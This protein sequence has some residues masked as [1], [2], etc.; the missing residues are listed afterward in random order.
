MGLCREARCDDGVG[1]D[2]TSI[3]LK[4]SVLLPYAPWFSV[5]GVCRQ[6]MGPN[7]TPEDVIEED[8]SRK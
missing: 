7:F 8:D 3:M 5:V 4:A 1:C 2:V 6:E